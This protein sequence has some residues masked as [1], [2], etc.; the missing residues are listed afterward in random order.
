[1]AQVC[2]SQERIFMYIGY[3]DD[4]GSSGK[5]L[6]DSQVPFQVIGGP[7]MDDESYFRSNLV[8]AQEIS[9][10]VPEEKW[11]EFEFHASDLYHANP[12]FDVLG[13]EK[14]LHLIEIALQWISKLDIPIVYGATD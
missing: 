13:R 2:E 3:I 12:P 4:S 5:N 9:N 14:C 1:M 6:D 10:L 11:E 7:V 8:L